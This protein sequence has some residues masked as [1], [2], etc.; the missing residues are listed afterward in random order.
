MLVLWCSHGIAFL[1]HQS[2][3]IIILL[4]AIESV[5]YFKV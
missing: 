5:H 1:D 2:I 3:I 4:F